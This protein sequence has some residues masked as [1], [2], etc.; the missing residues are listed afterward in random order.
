LHKGVRKTSANTAPK[1][2]VDRGRKCNTATLAPAILADPL[3][4]TAHNE[5]HSTANKSKM[6]EQSTD[7]QISHPTSSFPSNNNVI[8]GNQCLPMDVGLPVPE[9][10]TIV[11]NTSDG[12][13]QVTVSDVV[14]ASAQSESDAQNAEPTEPTEPPKKKARTHKSRASLIAETESEAGPSNL[15]DHR[16]SDHLD[17]VPIMSND[18]DEEYAAPSTSTAGKRKTKISNSYLPY[19]QTA[20]EGKLPAYGRPPIWSDKRQPLC[21]TL[22]YYKAYQSGVY[23]HDGKVYGFMVDKEIGPR[24]KFEEEIYISRV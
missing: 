15:V 3:I 13:S 20:Q 21:E 10:P 17:F 1:K 23:S 9:V 19:R 5:L 4:K 11:S 18:G 24:D 6:V 22:P 14:H 2:G 8:H 12:I 7:S 16:D